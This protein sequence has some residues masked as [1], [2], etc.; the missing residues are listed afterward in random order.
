[1]LLHRLKEEDAP[2][3]SP[4]ISAGSETPASSAHTAAKSKKVRAVPHSAPIFLTSLVTLSEQE[5]GVGSGAIL[6]Q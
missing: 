4:S 2:A 3:V 6:I 5:V 1:M